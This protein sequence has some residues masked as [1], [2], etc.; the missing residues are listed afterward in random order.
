MAELAHTT[1]ASLFQQYYEEILN[2]LMSKLGSRDQALDVT[3]ETDFRI[4][5]Q[6]T[7]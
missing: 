2:F 3:Q 5:N 7:L 4:L 6:K 1:N